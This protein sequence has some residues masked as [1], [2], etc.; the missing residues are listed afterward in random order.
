MKN[1][2]SDLLIR[3]I[4]GIHY[5][6]LIFCWFCDL[7]TEFCDLKTEIYQT[8]VLFKYVNTVNRARPACMKAAMSVKPVWLQQVK[9]QPYLS[10]QLKNHIRTLG[11]RRRMRGK[12]AGRCVQRCISAMHTISTRDGAPAQLGERMNESLAEAGPAEASATTT[13]T[14]ARV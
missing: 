5:S 6:L 11:I 14:T 1:V 8:R 12:R 2:A 7:K 9:G 13:N 3:I 4:T 10:E